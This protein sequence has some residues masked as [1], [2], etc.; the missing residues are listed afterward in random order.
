MIAKERTG[1]QRMRAP[2]VA[3]VLGLVLPIT[4]HAEIISVPPAAPPDP[5]V[6]LP[7]VLRG[8]PAAPARPVPCPPGY[9]LS[10]DYG[11]VAPSASDYTEGTP[12]Y[13]YWPDYGFGYPLGGY[14][15][16]G[17]GTTRVHR[18]GFR[19]GHRFHARAGFH[20]AA[21]LGAPGARIGHMGGFGRR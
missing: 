2:I 12:G 5:A 19:G 18:F 9:S 10:S 21:K 6:S 3:L 17:F 8:S 11:C 20:H 13:D 14:P 16:L 1:M 15:N 4:I 7:T